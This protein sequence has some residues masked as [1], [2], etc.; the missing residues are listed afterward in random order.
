MLVLAKSKASFLSVGFISWYC[1]GWQYM[2]MNYWP[3][4]FFCK[5]VP[6]RYIC[7]GF[8]P[9]TLTAFLP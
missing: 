6:A 8:R 1:R 3:T 2:G 9:N 7:Y 5:M 4:K